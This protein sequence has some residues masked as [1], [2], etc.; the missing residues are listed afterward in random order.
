MDNEQSRWGAAERSAARRLL[1]FSSVL[2]VLLSWGTGSLYNRGHQLLAGLVGVLAALA[3]I[4][5]VISLVLLV[6]P[7]TR[8]HAGRLA[9]IFFCLACVLVI[10][11][12]PAVA[13]YLTH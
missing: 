11:G 12:V 9:K 3:G 4:V 5:A 13:W 6:A 8:L 1:V 10:V 2:Y 7:G